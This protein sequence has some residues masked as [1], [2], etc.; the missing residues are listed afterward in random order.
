MDNG[1]IVK[2]DI[3]YI[4]KDDI[5]SEEL[6][7]SLRS[8]CEN[9]TYNQ[10]WFYCGC[11]KDIKPDRYIP[12]KQKGYN[13][14]DK[15]HSTIEDIC[16]NDEITPNF[17]LFNDDFF[18]MQPYEQDIPLSNGSLEYLAYSIEKRNGVES[19]YTQYLKYT[20]KVL[21]E[22]GYD[23]LSYACH[24]PLLINR[25]QGLQTLETFPS[26]SLFRS[27]YGNHHKLQG[28]LIDDVKIVDYNTI[29]DED[30]ILLST[31]EDSFEKGQV[32]KFIRERF[33]E[34]CQYEVG[35]KKKKKLKQNIESTTFQKV[36]KPIEPEE[37]EQ[38]KI[39]EKQEKKINK[40]KE[41]LIQI[42]KDYFTF[43][44]EE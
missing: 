44:Y 36:I 2:N 42:K 35:W 27:T 13:K 19:F 33:P 31:Y 12:F 11:P 40:F 26:I 8:V 7:Y 20:S 41:I 4:L 6:R 14:L 43:P 37:S 21:K 23:N 17:Y 15:V 30:C 39:V 10:I 16:K 18:I 24:V 38:P 9:F 32:G 34:P 5:N 29:P 28:K 25:Q 1:S 22:R 3:V